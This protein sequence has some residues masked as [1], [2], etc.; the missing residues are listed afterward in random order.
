[1]LRT[2]PGDRV[3]VFNASNGEFVATIAAH[4]KKDTSLTLGDQTHPPHTATHTLHLVFTPFKK[5]RADAVF[6]KS[7]ELGATHFHPVLTEHTEVRD[8]NAARI[9]AQLIEAAEQCER[10]DIPT[11]SPLI[12]LPQLLA[13]W[14]DDQPLYT[15]VE[16][17]DAVPLY[18]HIDTLQTAPDI[19]VLVGPAGGWSESEKSLLQTHPKIRAV[20][21]GED[22]LRSD[23]AVV[24]MLSFIKFVRQL[25]EKK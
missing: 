12:P 5:S 21:L 15:A 6:E 13:A 17:V 11:L 25:K 4:T 23:T 16:R 22:I 10:L 20:S 24:S 2:Q 8:L 1:M 9:T 19:A 18:T 3:R 14:P 7:V